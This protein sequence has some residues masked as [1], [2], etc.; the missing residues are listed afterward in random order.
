MRILLGIILLLTLLGCETVHEG[1]KAGG[2]VVGKTVD[3]FG[4]VTEGAAEA[5]Q[6]E[7]TAEDNPYGR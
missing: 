6:G 5:M 4:G 3:T 7:T 1:A 2:N